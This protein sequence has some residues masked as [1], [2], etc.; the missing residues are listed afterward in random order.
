MATDEG[1]G[2]GTEL[3]SFELRGISAFIRFLLGLFSGSSLPPPDTL[4][5][6]QIAGFCCFMYAAGCVHMLFWSHEPNSRSSSP[7][8][9]GEGVGTCDLFSPTIHLG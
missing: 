6:L 7:Q 3:F 8:S 4:K 9:S 5:T 1:T 2:K